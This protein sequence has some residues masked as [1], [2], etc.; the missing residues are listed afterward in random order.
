VE[1]EA[2]PAPTDEEIVS[3]ILTGEEELY[4]ELVG[5]F[6]SRI[7]AHLTRVVGSREDAAELAQ[8]IFL[9][10]FQ[11]LRRYNPEYRF[12]TWIFRIASNAGIDFL[13]KRRI[14]TVSLDAPVETEQ[15]SQ[16]REYP[17]AEPGP[18]AVL[19]NRERR[20][21]IGREIAALPPEFRDLIS[22]R[23]FAGL[24]YEEIAIAKKMPLGTVK[25]KLFRAR[26]VLKERLAG[27]LM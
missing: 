4:A 23:H 10:A 21:R 11:A 17:T 15:G 18:H 7:V 16:A 24:S 22:L 13:R 2:K 5:R 20:D 8:E 14:S 9:R 25:N 19:R 12:S 1:L 27:E 6:Q 3:R 26:A